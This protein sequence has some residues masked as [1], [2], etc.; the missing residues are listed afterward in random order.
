MFNKRK[1]EFQQLEVAKEWAKRVD[2]GFRPHR[3]IAVRPV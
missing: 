3:N 2:M 1:I